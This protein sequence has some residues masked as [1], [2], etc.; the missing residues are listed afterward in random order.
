M[1]N[2]FDLIIDAV[3]DNLVKELRTLVSED[4]PSRAGLVRAGQLQDNPLKFGISVLT[5]TN[6]KDDPKTWPHAVTS[7]T[8]EKLVSNPFSYEIGGGEFWYRRFSTQILQ[9]WPPNTSRELSRRYA[10]NVLARAEYAI[11]TTPLGIGP[12]D[13]GEAPIQ[14][15]LASSFNKEGGGGSQ[16]IWRGDIYWQC[17]TERP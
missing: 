4:D 9:F 8:G 6:D 7:G 13:L 5:F 1:I 16:F 2:V 17:L 15:Y 12:D 14:I 3:N 10:G 11:K